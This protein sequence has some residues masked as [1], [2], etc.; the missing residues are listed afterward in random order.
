MDINAALGIVLTIVL[1]LLG[2]A[3]I[4]FVIELIKTLR[5]AQGTIKSLEPTMKNVEDITTNIQ[6]T[7]AK[8]DP[9]MDRAQLTLDTVNL[10]MMRVDEI[11]ADVSVI[12]DTASSA[13]TAVD[14]ITSAPMKAVNNVA[15]RV[16]S[17][18]GGKS[19]SEESAKLAEQRVA[20]AQALEDYKAA[21]EK[22]AKKGD[23]AEVNEAAITGE[24][25]P[26]A[27]SDEPPKS[28]VQVEEGGELVIDPDVIAES[29][30][31]DEGPDEK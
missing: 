4:V 8:I 22:S 5:S 26:I 20:V 21:E 12:T 29:P 2:V 23:E 11:L 28:Y 15:M 6:P 14:N 1:I 9:L 24:M 16:K 10:E 19:A 30:F 17:A 25:E 31:F 13:T 3:L 27:S 7:L 18:F